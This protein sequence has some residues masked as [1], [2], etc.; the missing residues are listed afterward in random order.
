MLS[1]EDEWQR[2]TEYPSS[3][4]LLRFLEA[5]LDRGLRLVKQA[6]DEWQKPSGVSSKLLGEIAR[7]EADIQRWLELAR[8]RHASVAHL[9][10]KLA[11]FASSVAGFGRNSPAERNV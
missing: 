5:D 8:D 2:T 9:D 1:P 4:A 10:R 6:R 7:V 3:K 11:E